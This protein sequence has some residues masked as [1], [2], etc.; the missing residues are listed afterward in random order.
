MHDST[1]RGSITSIIDI[2]VRSQFF[3]ELY[4]KK[5]LLA[6]ASTL[7]LSGERIVEILCISV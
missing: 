1:L 6:L 4:H 2:M 5:C 7:K 3:T